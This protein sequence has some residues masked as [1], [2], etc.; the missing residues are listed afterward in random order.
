MLSENHDFFNDRAWVTY[1]EHRSFGR[2]DLAHSLLNDQHRFRAELVSVLTRCRDAFFQ[3]EWERS[4]PQLTATVKNLSRQLATSDV[5]HTVESL[6]EI[7]SSRGS[8]TTVFFDKLQSANVTVDERGLLLIP[9]LRGWP[10]LMVKS[11]PGL[12]IVIHFP[13]RGRRGQGDGQSQSDVRERL[14]ALAEPGR[15]ELCRHLIGESITTSELAVRTGL[16]APAVSRHLR[17]LREAGMVSS[18]REG[19]QVFHR[20]HSSLILQL[21]NDVM[22][23]I[24]R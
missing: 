4:E 18:Q 15:W 14:L 12:P 7:S 3:D 9:S 21:G 20:M 8:T 24:V 1:C 5:L 6:S 10:H 16:S 11:S 19:R 17:V 23:A 13:A 2:G 22:S